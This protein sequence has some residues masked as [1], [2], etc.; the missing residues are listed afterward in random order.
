MWKG[1]CLMTVNLPQGSPTFL[2]LWQAFVPVLALTA[3]EANRAHVAGMCRWYSASTDA[4]ASRQRLLCLR[5]LL[6]VLACTFTPVF[7]RN[8]TPPLELDQVA[9]PVG[10][11]TSIDALGSESCSVS[12][13]SRYPT[14]YVTHV[15]WAAVVESQSEELTAVH[16]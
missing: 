2:L 10:A 3:V 6:D 8:R 12:L 16:L 11:S 5:M 4:C 1:H 13:S 14:A 7:R 9:V 15:P